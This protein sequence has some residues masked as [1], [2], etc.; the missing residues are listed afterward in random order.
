MKVHF[1]KILLFFFPLNILLTSYHVN[2]KNKQYI[3]P[4]HIRTSI[5]RVLSEC[6][7][8]TSIYDDDT[9]MKSVKENFD[10]QTSRR[11]EEYEKRMIKNRQKCKEQCDKD[12][13]EIILKDKVQKSLAE[14]IEKGCLRCGCGLGGVAA[15]IGLIGGV[16]VNE[17]KK[18]ALLAAESSAI[19]EG[20]VAGEA[21]GIK[22]GIE[23]VISGIEREFGV[24]TDGVQG[25]QSLFTANTYNDVT[26]IARAII[27]EYDPSSCLIGGSGAPET[28]CTWVKVKSDAAPKIPGKHVSTNDLVEKAVGTIVSDAEPVATAAAQQATDEVIQRSIAVVDAKY[29]AAVTEATDAATQAGI[30]TVVAQLEIFVSSFGKDAVS[31]TSIVT[32]TN[33]K[34][35]AA[36]LENAK[37][38]LGETCKIVPKKSSSSFCNSV[39]H[40]G[41]ETTF[42]GYAKAG[43]EAYNAT[44]T[45]KIATLK[46]AK[47]WL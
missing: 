27:K 18:A 7:T 45:S 46:P 34:C 43:S 23:A 11:F 38:L 36:L 31:L 21:A 24:S 14:K 22:A 16:T 20:A 12:I 26:M 29:E 37:K 25:L 8:H 15:S 35:G 33:Y 5:S 13:Q 42:N 40:Y 44:Y 10:R 2:N 17:L 1:P 28:F 41:G 4:R 32:P 3:T 30:D 9:E 47:F 6:D 39:I 19:A